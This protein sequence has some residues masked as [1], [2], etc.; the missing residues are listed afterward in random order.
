MIEAI[1]SSPIAPLQGMARVMRLVRLRGRLSPDEATL[2]ADG[3]ASAAE[4]CPPV[5]GVL[6]SYCVGG[7]SEEGEAQGGE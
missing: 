1:H 5:N 3:W 7:P 2:I 4:E 6:L